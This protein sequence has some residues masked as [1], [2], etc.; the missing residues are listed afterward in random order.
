MQAA[1][2]TSLLSRFQLAQPPLHSSLQVNLFWIASLAPDRF[3]FVTKHAPFAALVF[4]N[5]LTILVAPSP[6]L[7]AIGKIPAPSFDRQ[8]AKGLP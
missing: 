1:L 5:L 2:R 6:Y 4:L 3:R 8:A 7:I